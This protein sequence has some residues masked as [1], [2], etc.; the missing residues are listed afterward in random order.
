MNLEEWT[1][2]GSYVT[3]HGRR[4][5]VV[6]TGGE[7]LPTLVI[8]HGYPTSSHDYHE[9]LPTLAKH[10]RVIVH[11]HIGFGLS[12]KPHDYSYS[13]IEQ[14]DQAI[15][16][17][18]ELGVTSARVFAHDYGTSVATELL[19]RWNRGLRPVETSANWRPVR[20][21]GRYCL[22]STLRFCDAIDRTGAGC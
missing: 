7:D 18:R 15:M 22:G 1:R 11:D 3:V 14:T 20:T 19:A 5:F 6:D 13:L 17:W 12:E 21:S 9:V 4:M 16:L 8:L 2:L 10:Y